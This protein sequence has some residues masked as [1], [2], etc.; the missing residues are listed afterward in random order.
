MEKQPDSKLA[1]QVLPAPLYAALRHVFSQGVAD[2]MLV[3]GSALAGYYA[4]HRR[5]DDLD[6]FVKDASAM[7]ATVLAVVSLQ[8]LGCTFHKKQSTPQFY[9]ATCELKGHAF[10]V[11]VVVD[12]NLF[13]AGGFIRVDDGV[14]VADLN[15]I[16]KLKAATLVS[17]CSEKDLY[18]LIWLLQ[19]FAGLRLESLVELG[20]EIDDGMNAEAM[21]I[22]LAGTTLREQACGFSIAQPQDKVF[23][24][25]NALKASLALSL[26]KLS[27]KQPLGP[28]GELIRALKE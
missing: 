15:T 8:N 17:R 18:D 4:G 1:S 16:L 9:D 11:Q 2:C 14:A 27:R 23:K 28:V 7:Q 21:L 3:G 26:D 6:L 22:S 12:A 19:H 25:V 10:T 20:R 13:A 24:Q 5:S